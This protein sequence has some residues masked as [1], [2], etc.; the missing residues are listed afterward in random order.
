MELSRKVTFAK[1]WIIFA[2][3]V[4]LGGHL[5]LGLMLHSPQRWPWQDAGLHG[6]L[7]GISVYVLVQVVRSCWW[8]VSPRFARHPDESQP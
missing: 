8:L 7:I 5:A 3:S 4:G 1:E 2:L 6:A